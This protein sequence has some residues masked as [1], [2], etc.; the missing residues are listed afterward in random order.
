M[1]G[2]SAVVMSALFE[3]GRGGV[4]GVTEGDGAIERLAMPT[5]PRLADIKRSMAS[6]A[7]QGAEWPRHDNAIGF[8]H[9]VQQWDAREPV[10]G[11]K[12]FRHEE[13]KARRQKVEGGEDR[14]N[15]PRRHC[16]Q[17]RLLKLFPKVR[18][19]GTEPVPLFQGALIGPTPITIKYY[20]ATRCGG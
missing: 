11:E 2:A 4:D 19:G 14:H 1:G 10:V 16:T 5:D 20:K 18:L 6:V 12:E 15:Q 3:K 7:G 9:I 17:L 8:G 13:V